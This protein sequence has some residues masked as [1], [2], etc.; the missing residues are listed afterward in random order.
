VEEPRRSPPR[1]P[2][3]DESLARRAAAGDDA[4]FGELSRRYTRGL[5]RYASRLVG[6]LALGEGIARRALRDARRE[7]RRGAHP[8]CVSPWLYRL[9][10]N[11]ALDL[12]ADSPGEPAVATRLPERQRQAFVLREVYG[13]PVREIAAE[14]GM[15]ADEVQQAQF[16]ARGRLVRAGALGRQGRTNGSAP[17]SAPRRASRPAVLAVAAAAVAL[18][19]G[20]PVAA[21]YAPDRADEPPRPLAIPPAGHAL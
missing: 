6:D 1:S 15:C 19:V 14:L 18:C 4:A 7:L 12:R 9:T 5:S 16:A 20:M 10:L 2:H 21:T 17:V 3:S 8:S 11:V 13:L